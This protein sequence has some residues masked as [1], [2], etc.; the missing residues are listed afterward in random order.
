MEKL[1]LFRPA[2]QPRV[3]LHGAVKG[4]FAIGVH[5]LHACVSGCLNY[6]HFHF[7]LQAHLPVGAQRCIAIIKF[8]FFSIKFGGQVCIA[9]RFTQGFIL[10]FVTYL[11][12]IRKTHI[13]RGRT[14]CFF[15]SKYC[16]P[17]RVP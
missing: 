3:G 1:D 7:V 5:L 10:N 4:I 16:Y 13:I 11:G 6:I 9:W 14:V 15:N 8:V 12:Q 17:G 2:F